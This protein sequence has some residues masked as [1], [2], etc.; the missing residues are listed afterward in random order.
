MLTDKKCIEIFREWA[1]DYY[2]RTTPNPFDH[3]NLPYDAITGP[4][5]ILAAKDIEEIV[6]KDCETEK[7]EA[8]RVAVETRESELK[9]KFDEIYNAHRSMGGYHTL[10]IMHTKLFPN[11]KEAGDD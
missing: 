10:A 2:H 1:N 7:A 4:A 8:V 5:F 9:A 6:R 3:E 11:R